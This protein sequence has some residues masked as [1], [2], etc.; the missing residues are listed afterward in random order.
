[1]SEQLTLALPASMSSPEGSPARARPR[2]GSVTG[3]SIPRPFCGERWPAPFAS[4]DPDTSSWRTWRTSLPSTT[5]PCG[6]RLSGT[7]PRSASISNGTAFQR[8]PS[9]PRTSVTGSSPLLPTP[10]AADGERAS[11][12]YGNGNLTLSG[13]LTLLPTPM[14]RDGRADGSQ[15]RR[16]AASIAAG[17]GKSVEQVVTKLLPTPT[18]TEGG[19]NRS[20]SPGATVRP[21]LETLVRLLPSPTTKD[22]TGAR[23]ATAKARD[24]WEPGTT[25]SDLEFEW[26]GASTRPLSAAGKRWSVQR[27]SLS[28]LFEEWMLGLPQ[29]WSDPDC[30]LSATE[31]SSSSE[32]WPAGDSSSLRSND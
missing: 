8:Q 20:A 30:L 31:F 27:P 3:S 7:W 5:E 18:A 23:N 26:S 19:H 29:G 15:N 22:A 12:T 10:T 14:A 25:L 2:R 4:F 9:A 21:A 16:S 17:G 13:A 24:G 11:A 32:N 1:M 28:A 6:E